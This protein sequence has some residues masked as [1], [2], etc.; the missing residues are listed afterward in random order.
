MPLTVLVELSAIVNVIDTTILFI[1]LLYPRIIGTA[2]AP[3]TIAVSVMF[4]S[5]PDVAEPVHTDDPLIEIDVSLLL[6]GTP[7][8]ETVM[9]AMVILLGPEFCKVMPVIV[10][11]VLVA[12]AVLITR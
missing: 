7:V 3:E 5:V 2:A 4:S 9:V 8:Q 6:A 10:L 11:P 12:P 1:V